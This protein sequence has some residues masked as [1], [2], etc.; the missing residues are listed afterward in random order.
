M[1]GTSPLTLRILAAVLVLLVVLVLV[2][3]N[4]GSGRFMLLTSRRYF[5]YS[6]HTVYN[7]NRNSP[8]G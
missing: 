6:I 4:T 2:G 3:R 7:D 8:S 5:E 1:E